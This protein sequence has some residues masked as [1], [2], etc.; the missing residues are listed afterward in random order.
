MQEARKEG[1]Q[2]QTS[3]E[4]ACCSKENR[5][6]IEMQKVNVRILAAEVERGDWIAALSRRAVTWNKLPKLIR[7]THLR[8]VDLTSFLP[9]EFRNAAAIIPHCDEMRVTNALFARSVWKGE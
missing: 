7:W 1:E 8:G 5:E 6:T 9:C 2:E 3:Q 4:E